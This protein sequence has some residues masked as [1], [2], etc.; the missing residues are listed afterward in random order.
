MAVGS[1]S[2]CVC[3]CVDAHADMHALNN[4][5]KALGF[6]PLV[7]SRKRTMTYKEPLTDEGGSFKVAVLKRLFC[8]LTYQLSDETFIQSHSRVPSSLI[9]TTNYHL[10][11]FI[12]LT[13]RVNVIPFLFVMDYQRELKGAIN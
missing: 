1:L 4:Y 3:V 13:R 7:R 12:H 6:I 8:K 9:I 11:Y 2:M 5:Q 10:F